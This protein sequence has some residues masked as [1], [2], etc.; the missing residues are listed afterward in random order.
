MQ[1]SYKGETVTVIDAFSS[2]GVLWLLITPGCAS[3]LK[4]VKARETN[5]A[6]RDNVYRPIRHYWSTDF[7]S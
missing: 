2:L 4:W 1:V 6:I 7:A 3:E 5:Y